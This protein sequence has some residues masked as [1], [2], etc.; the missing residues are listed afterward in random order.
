MS[1]TVCKSAALAVCLCLTA[2]VAT[3]EDALTSD[4]VLDFYVVNQDVRQVLQEIERST[5]I[6]S[7]VSKHVR[8]RLTS[9]RLAGEP[10]DIMGTI[11]E[12]LALDW[13]VFNG[14]LHVSARTETQTRLV[15]LDEIDATVALTT[16]QRSGLPT[17]LFPSQI[18][19][20]G[21]ALALTGPPSFLALAETVLETLPGKEP[22]PARPKPVVAH[23]PKTVVERRGTERQV[24]EVR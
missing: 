21:A 2:P 17:A 7:A 1:M 4:A 22:V 19:G 3:G 9:V 12:R 8:G 14:V 10:A 6:R 11:S 15:R 16:L 13:F 20:D 23:T 24:V 18:T 5:G